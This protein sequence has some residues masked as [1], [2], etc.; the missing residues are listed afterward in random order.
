MFILLAL[1]QLVVADAICVQLAGVLR[2]TLRRDG[3][4]PYQFIVLVLTVLVLR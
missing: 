2:F 3:R 1:A 4:V